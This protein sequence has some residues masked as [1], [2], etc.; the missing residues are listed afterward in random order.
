MTS[1]RSSRNNCKDVKVHAL[2]VRVVSKHTSSEYAV[3]TDY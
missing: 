3:L 2:V 1:S